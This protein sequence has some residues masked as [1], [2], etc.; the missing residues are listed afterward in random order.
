MSVA[1][2]ERAPVRRNAALL[3]ET[4]RRSAE[5][6]VINT[7]Q[8]GMAR[9]MNFQAIVELVGDKLREVFNTGDIVIAWRGPDYP[10]VH[11]L[12]EYQRGVRISVPPVRVDP[13]GRMSRA[14]DARRPVVANSRAEMKAWGLRDVVGKEPSLSTAMVPIFVGERTVGAIALQNCERENA[15][16]EAEVR[17][18]TTVAASMGTALENARLLEE[19]Q[20]HAREVSESLERQTATAEVLQVISG[21]MA[22]AK[23]VFEKILDSCSRLFGAGDPAVCLIDGDLLCIGAYHGKFTEE[24]KQAF[25]RPLAGTISDLALRQ[26]SVLYRPSVLAAD[27]IPEY[28][29]EV[30][31]QR[32]DFSVV[33]APMT[34]NG[35]A[36]AR[37][38]SS[39]RRR[40]SFRNPS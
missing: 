7:I 13:N 15:F 6:A 23:P 28:I 12:Y 2:R 5:L 35:G 17:L 40:G 26:G 27:D 21:S 11:S 3:K 20:R 8:Q 14:F 19:T 29:K 34:W 38:T 16:G 30:A 36:S 4:E 22:D 24:V 37:S 32:G 1:L 10:L 25:P 31:R 39:A 18:L 9:E 33:N